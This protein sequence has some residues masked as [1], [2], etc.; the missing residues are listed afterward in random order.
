[1][2][3]TFCEAFQRTAANFPDDVALRSFGGCEELTWSQLAG[4]VAAA[5]GT[6]AE[7]GVGR[8]DTVGFLLA[9]RPEFHVLDIA[10]LHL[11]ATPYSVYTTSPPEQI[12]HCLRNACSRMI[13]TEPAF[14]EVVDAAV[15]EAPEVGT[16]LLV[17]DAEAGPAADLATVSGPVNAD[18]VAVLIYTSGTT[19]PPKGVQ[20]T[21]RNLMASYEATRAAV[22]AWG[23]RGRL[24]SY[25]PH[26]HLADRF[27][28]HYPAILTGSSITCVNDAREVVAALPTVRPT[29]F[30]AVPRIWEKL[31]A[32]L[33]G[34][35]GPDDPAEVRAA[36]RTRLGLDEARVLLSGAAPIGPDVLSFFAGIGMEILE[37]YG[38]SECSAIICINRPGDA[39]IGTVG[40]PCP[41]VELRLESDGEVLI[42]GDMVMPGYRA[43]PD[44]TREA[45][46]DDGWLR[47]GDVGSFDADGSLRI[48]DRKKE[49]IVNAAGKNMSPANIENTIKSCSPL[50]GHAVAI[51]DR[52]PYNTALLVLDPDAAAGRRADDPEVLAAV[53][54]AV[55]TANARLSRVEQIKRWTLLADEWLP[56]G[57][58]LTPTSKLKRKA[59]AE[60]YAQEIERL[61]A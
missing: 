23:E 7:L 38:M 10:A 57:P 50:I 49:L 14:A 56:G 42:R 19:G 22:P 40:R 36:V 1:M 32:A 4:R 33:E 39:R 27:C 16:V 46:D 61:Y 43:D 6:L 34:S 24:L 52:R 35:V 26:A 3:T 30:G 25:L 29:I 13:V 58:E 21:H 5:A 8:G 37:C 12:A 20:L 55:Q 44:R 2:S 41:G 47:T 53:A 28:S 48:V 51:G 15:A 17:Q 54:A 18:D 9:N 45:I 60:R 31:K 11:G 59:I